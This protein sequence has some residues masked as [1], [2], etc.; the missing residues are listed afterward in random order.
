M[1]SL[2]LRQPKSKQPV[3]GG[4][5]VA[6]YYRLLSICVLVGTLC[7]CITGCSRTFWRTQADQESYGIIAERMTDPRWQL[8]RMDVT[9]NVN[10]RFFDP[11][12]PDCP[13]LPPDDPA[14]HRY[15]HWMNGI[16]GYKSWHEF[17][18]TFS[19]ENPQWLQGLGLSP[20]QL[21][22]PSQR[23]GQPTPKIENLTLIE[24]LELAAINSRDYQTEIENL[25]LSALSLTFERFQF[26]VRFLGTFG[27]PFGDL[28]YE[29]IPDGQNSLTARTG[30]G[31]SQLL[32]SGAQWIVELTNNTLWIFSGDNSTNS[33]SLLSYSLVQPLLRGAGRKVVLEELTQSER[34]VLY[35][36]RDLARF[37]KEF[38][39]EIVSSYLGLLQ[40]YQGIDNREN[41][42]RLLRDQLTQL[43]FEANRQQN[44]FT[45]TLANLDDTIVFPSEVADQLRYD[46]FQKILIW[47]GPMSDEQITVLRN[48]TDDPLFNSAISEI[49]QSQ[50][51]E[52]TNLE[53][54]QLASRLADSQN[55]LRIA[56]QNIQDSLDQFKL[57]L[58]IPTDFI[59]SIDRSLI[60]Q[61]QLIDPKL[62]DMTEYIDDFIAQLGETADETSDEELR[63]IVTV[64]QEIVHR[65]QTETI[66][67]VKQDEARM[68]KQLIQRR[69]AQ[70]TDPYLD[71]VQSDNER[72]RRLL[73]K[74]IEDFK[75]EL[76][77][78]D[79]LSNQLAGPPL[80]L[81]QKAEFLNN[82]RTIREQLI[83]RSQAMQVNQIGFRVEMIE[84]EPFDISMEEA[85]NIGLQNRLDLMNARGAVMDARRLLEVAANDLEA[86]LDVRVEGD[87]RTPTI[88]NRPFD[89]RGDFSSF[90]AGIGFTAPLDQI[91]ER[92]AYRATLINYQQVK[93]NYMALEDAIKNQIRES[94]R[95]LTTLDQN[96]ETA[97]QAVRINARQYDLNSETA[98][99]PSRSGGNSQGLNILNAL[100]GVLSAQ[101]QLISF[102]V[103]YERNRLNIYR[104]MGIMVIDE[105]GIWTDSFY[106]EQ[107]QPVTPQ[108]VPPKSSKLKTGPVAT[109]PRP[110]H[111]TGAIP[112]TT[113]VLQ[114]AQAPPA[115]TPVNFAQTPNGSQTHVQKTSVSI[116]G[117]QRRRRS[118]L[119]VQRLQQ[120]QSSPGWRSRPAD[121]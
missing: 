39:V 59:V 2:L 116:P 66:P 110:S 119:E 70:E 74:T 28:E 49:I 54:V 71:R 69:L 108:V 65:F 68:E 42:I 93:R 30:F 90:R 31:I 18:Q 38:F 19:V 55:A 106:Q 117:P 1:L 99:D 3:S 105:R 53:V 111:P 80:T 91:A 72:D 26:N 83:Q 89:F 9:P 97:R 27:E 17:G 10:S 6:L 60:D 112:P 58:G 92:N 4:E 21:C 35:E 86:V 7:C 44:R 85:V 100:D 76:F 62:S 36:T 20:D 13:P 121:R 47:V 32:P 14:A 45:E 16:K 12:N 84:L 34:D 96:F 73:N 8:P 120:Q 43:E 41:N 11:Y 37:R 95:A 29:S 64:L 78:I 103:Q 107:A 46:D 56:K 115:T 50:T 98:N 88:G 57:Q 77:R 61:F 82:V 48:I 63:N 5:R 52:S 24:A 81:E 104:D 33:T 15:M 23:L 25:Y 40:Q 67:L 75:F 87:I 118:L 114:L 102:W 22:D 113:K 101:N 94:H 109:Q 79:N 51:V